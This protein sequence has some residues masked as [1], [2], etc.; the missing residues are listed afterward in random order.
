M[1]LTDC[2]PRS[3]TNIAIIGGNA[4]AEIAQHV[5][6]TSRGFAWPANGIHFPL[7][8]GKEKGLDGDV[9]DELDRII[10]MF[11]PPREPGVLFEAAERLDKTY[12]HEYF[13]AVGDNGLRMQIYEYVKSKTNREPVN[14]IHRAAVV[15]GKVGHGNLILAGAVINVGATVGNCTIINTNSTVEHHCVIEDGAQIGPGAVLAGR[16]KVGYK[17]SVWSNATV[18]PNGVVEEGCVIGAG[19]TLMHQ[20]VKYHTY[21]GSPANRI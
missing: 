7:P 21:V 14:C 12:I 20:T 13:I 2:I 1:N 4:G 19:S 8:F 6:K 5:F 3:S 11:K 10:S 18:L 16:V 17:A 9:T 15:D